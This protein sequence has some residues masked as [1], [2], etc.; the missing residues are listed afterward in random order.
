M[1]T[2]QKENSCCS[3]YALC[4]LRSAT[5]FHRQ[6]YGGCERCAVQHIRG[7]GGNLA[8]GEGGLVSLFNTI[9]SDEIFL[10]IIEFRPIEILPATAAVRLI[11]VLDDFLTPW[12]NREAVPILV[13]SDC[14]HGSGQ[15]VCRGEQ[16]IE[17]CVGK[18]ML[19]RDVRPDIIGILMAASFESKLHL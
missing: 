9:P 17:D 15:T 5:V 7:C 3:L 18:R 14:A 8:C 6:R 2:K 10:G 19:L 4:V 12:A 16:Q 13:N 1:E 11:F